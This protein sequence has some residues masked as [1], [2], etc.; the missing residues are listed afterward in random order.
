VIVVGIG[1]TGSRISEYTPV[2]DSTYGG[3][4][5]DAYLDFVEDELMPWVASNYRTLSG[6]DNTL[7]G[8]SSLGGLISFYASWTRSDVFGSAICM[9][10]SFWWANEWM[11]GEV[12][13]HSGAKVPARFYVD[14]GSDGAAET[15]DMRDALEALGYTHGVDLHHWYEPSHGHNE[16]AWRDRFPIPV[17]RLLPWG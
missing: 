13:S 16:A 7:I 3:G 1:N 12:Q 15:F 8:G 4:N 17:D 11:T 14:S 2:W 6:P 5:G 10:S 9:S